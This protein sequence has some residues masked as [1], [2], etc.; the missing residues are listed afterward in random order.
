MQS[1]YARAVE[2][3]NP[4]VSCG[5]AADRGMWGGHTEV[6][7]QSLGGNWFF[8]CLFSSAEA[9]RVGFKGKVVCELGFENVWDLNISR[10]KV[11]FL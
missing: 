11:V 2:K 9:I 4:L 6:S 3:V 1:L 8:V 10:W 7:G 5:Q